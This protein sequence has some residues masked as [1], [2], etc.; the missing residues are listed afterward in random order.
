[1]TRP[2]V[3]VV[4]A[5]T[6]QRPG[7][8]AEAVASVTAQDYDGNVATI[9]VYD[10]TDEPA[11]PVETVG[12][13]ARSVRWVRS[14]RRGLP[15]ARNAGVAAGTAPWVAFLDDDDEWFPAK[16]DA[17]M[18]ASGDANL[19]GSG[20][21][22]VDQSGAAI[23][24]AAPIHLVT[25]RDLLADR[26]M[27]L[28]PSTFLVRREALLRVGGVDED[29]PG[30]YAEDYD[31]LLRLA[32]L[33]P[34]VCVSEPLVRVRWTTG[35]YFFSRWQTIVT[36]LRYLLAKHPDFVE[37]RRGHA[38]VLGQIAF[39]EAAMGQ[40]RRALGSALAA[41]RRNPTERRAPLA[42]AVALRVV[43]AERV[44]AALHRRGR[45]I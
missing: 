36:A 33:G 35:S 40:R 31:L 26:I 38:R 18:R 20:V 45:G 6:G 4:I 12:D 1:V 2:D 11:D 27:E 10:S 14:S 15:A 22:I 42:A 39:A 28:H 44:Q 21:E 19:V 17:Q 37:S 8:L 7:L 23:S 24:R 32:A 3:D 25:R 5:T 16:L 34:I 30:G 13:P 41:L 9:V 43:S 29:I